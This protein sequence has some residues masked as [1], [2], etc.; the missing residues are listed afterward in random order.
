M[1]IFHRNHLQYAADIKDKHFPRVC[2][3]WCIF[4]PLCH[5]VVYMRDN[6]AF[7]SLCATTH[8]HTSPAH[9]F[10]NVTNQPTAVSQ[11][12]RGHISHLNMKSHIFEHF[13]VILR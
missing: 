11:R 7:A 3:L 10:G 5:N 13:V 12:K 6:A 8:T 4:Q 1:Q 2:G 9:I